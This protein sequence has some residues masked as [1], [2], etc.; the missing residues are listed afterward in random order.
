[1]VATIQPDNSV[2]FSNNEEQCAAPCPAYTRRRRDAQRAF[3]EASIDSSR[4]SAA[5]GL[6]S[7]ACNVPRS[8]LPPSTVVVLLI[9][10][11]SVD[12]KSDGA[13]TIRAGPPPRNVRAACVAFS[14]ASPSSPKSRTTCRRRRRASCAH[15]QML[16]L[17]VETSTLFTSES[18]NPGTQ[19]THSGAQHRAATAMQ[20]N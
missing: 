20:S 13:S 10:I 9:P 16:P 11:S 7:L 2:N 12:L 19:L 3:R 1:M 18:V 15:S 4:V 17:K 6:F 8:A 5:A 14:S